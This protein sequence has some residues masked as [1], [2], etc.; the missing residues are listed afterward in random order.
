MIT[1]NH[2]SLHPGSQAAQKVGCICD[3][4]KNLSGKYWHIQ[5]DC[6]VHGYTAGDRFQLAAGSRIVNTMLADRH[7]EERHKPIED[8]VGLAFKYR[9]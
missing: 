7:K 8:H 9:P 2:R 4:A 5:P 6:R 3:W 1:D